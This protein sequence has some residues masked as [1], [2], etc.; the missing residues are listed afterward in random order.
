MKIRDEIKA[1]QGKPKEL[2]AFL[3]DS[4]GKDERLFP[5]VIDILKSGSDVEKGT[6]AEIMQ[7]VSKNKPELL[8]PY[9][10]VIVEY[11][12]YK[13]PRVKWGMTESIGNM[14]QKYPIQ[15]EKA[16]PKLLPNTKDKG[17]VVRWC[18]AYAL[19]EIAKNNSQARST[20]LQ[21]IEEIVKE[22]Q[23][24]GVRNVYLKAIKVMNKQ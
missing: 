4:I 13:A 1:W 17:T 23:N 2:V 18:A 5:H 3:T 14:A 11:I 6:V 24:N 7:Q 9:I 16:I 19:S 12:N 21:K 8:L 15:V 20:L 10:E 22:E